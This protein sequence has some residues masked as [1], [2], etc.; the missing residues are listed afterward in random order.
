VGGVVGTFEG[1]VHMD[2]GPLRDF[3]QLVSFE[4]AVTGIGATSEISVK[5]FSRG[6]ATLALRLERPVELLRELEE[7]A[8][9]EFKVRSLRDDQLIVD[10]D[11][12]RAAA[13]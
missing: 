2:I 3:S 13:G 5:R 6:R 9:F 12:D 10:V 1:T 8:P 11:G 4:E 7:R